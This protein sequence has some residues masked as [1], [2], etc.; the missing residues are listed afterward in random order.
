MR[1]ILGVVIALVVISSA[2][3]A[4]RN[5]ELNAEEELFKQ[6]NQ[7]FLEAGSVEQASPEEAR[8]LYN[9]AVRRYQKIIDSGVQNGKLYYNLGNCYYR[10]GKIGKAILEYRRAE[11]YMKH[12]QNLLQ[13]LAQAR[14]RTT[15]K[16]VES[17]ETKIIETLLFWH[18]D[19]STTTRR[20]VFGVFFVLFWLGLSIRLFTNK[21]PPSWSLWIGGVLWVAILASLVAEPL[22]IENTQSGVVLSASVDTRKGDGENYQPA[23]TKPLHE[24]AEFELL[25]KR[26]E[27]LHIEL[28]DG[29]RCWIPTKTAG[30][31]RGE[32]Y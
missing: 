17:E 22:E 29:R 6:A 26:G 20:V 16:V 2:A 31:V 5:A 28:V 25:E 8:K 15:D 14:S 4:L 32:E 1:Y 7:A 10:L 18:Y 11:L 3:L 30:L 19:I 23:F 24:G 9:Q 12:D 21:F 27:W 13:N